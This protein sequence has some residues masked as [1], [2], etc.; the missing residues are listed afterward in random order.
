MFDKRYLIFPKL[1]P[2][3]SILALTLALHTTPVRA[4]DVD[5]IEIPVTE[6]ESLKEIEEYYSNPRLF[7]NELEEIEDSQGTD[8][9]ALLEEKPRLKALCLFIKTEAEKGNPKAKVLYYIGL[10]LQKVLTQEQWVD[11]SSWLKHQDEAIA[12]PLARFF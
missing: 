9:F 5:P 12:A 2:F 10:A 1:S 6:E 8:F 11:V 7:F 4:M 3:V